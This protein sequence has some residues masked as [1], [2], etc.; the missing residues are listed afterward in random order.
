MEST[1][2]AAPLD[3]AI[4]AN[5]VP[6]SG[7]EGIRPRLITSQTLGRTKETSRQAKRPI[8]FAAFATKVSTGAVMTNGDSQLGGKP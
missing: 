7:I 3:H 2:T 5:A 4:E 1:S 8:N 6:C